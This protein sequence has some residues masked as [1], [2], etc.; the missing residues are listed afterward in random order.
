MTVF[1][2][3]YRGYKLNRESVILNAPEE[4]GIYGLFGAL[5]IFVGDADNIR[6][7]LLQ[8]LTENDPAI[9]LYQP[10]GFAFELVAQHQRKRRMEQAIQ[11]LEPLLQF[12]RAISLTGWVPRSSGSTRA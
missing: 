5:W 4:S 10:S 8:H 7:R 1:K 3:C 2:N 9:R 6:A 12:S 11:Q